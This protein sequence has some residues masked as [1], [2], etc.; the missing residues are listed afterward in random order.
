MK[1]LNDLPREEETDEAS[2]KEKQMVCLPLV[3]KLCENHKD[4]LLE[5]LS[6]GGGW[7]WWEC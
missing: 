7:R 1:G 2:F 4:F 6:K 5:R 3:E